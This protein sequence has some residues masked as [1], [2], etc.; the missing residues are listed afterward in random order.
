MSGQGRDTVW[1]KAKS[2]SIRLSR[3]GFR[4]SLRSWRG[5]PG[6]WASYLLKVAKHGK[7]ENIYLVRFHYVRPRARRKPEG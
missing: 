1:N 5:I 2:K 3:S 4:I 6:F 7:G